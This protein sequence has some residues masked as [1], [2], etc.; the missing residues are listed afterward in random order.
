MSRHYC[1]TCKQWV[2]GGENNKKWDAHNRSRAHAQ[3]KREALFG[4]KRPARRK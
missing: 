2:E 1:Y 3:K 4:K